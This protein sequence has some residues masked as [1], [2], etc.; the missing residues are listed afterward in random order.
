M[1]LFQGYTG[2]FAQKGKL[3]QPF[4]HRNKPVEQRQVPDGGAR[5]HL[6][7]GLPGVSV[8]KQ[9]LSNDGS[10]DG[11]EYMAV[12]VLSAILFCRFTELQHLSFRQEKLTGCSPTGR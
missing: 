2:D 7:H 5:L 11:C 8:T 10:N 12:V 6:M 9:P 4:P 3:V 1:V